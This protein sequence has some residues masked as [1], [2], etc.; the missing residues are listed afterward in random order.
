MN[1]TKTLLWSAELLCEKYR[2]TRV[3]NHDD[4]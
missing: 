1:H 4:R 3:V 2:F